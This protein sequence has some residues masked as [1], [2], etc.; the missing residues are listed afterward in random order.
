MY[1]LRDT[2]GAAALWTA[3]LRFRNGGAPIDV[4]GMDLALV[5]NNRLSRNEVYFDRAAIAAHLIP[6]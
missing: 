1:P 6:S 5:E 2:D 4:S 3:T